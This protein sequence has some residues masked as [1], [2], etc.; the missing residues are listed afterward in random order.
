MAN[1]TGT[2]TVN[3]KQVLEVDAVPSAGAG[4]PA[5]IGSL[6]MFN[7]AGVGE[8]Y[9]K[10]GAADTAWTLVDTNASD[11]HLTGNILTGGAPDTPNEFIGSTND[12]DFIMRRNNIEQARLQ[13]SQFLIG[14]N[15]GIGGIL[16]VTPALAGDDIIKSVLSPALNPVISVNR[17]FRVTTVGAVTSTFDVSVPSGYNAKIQADVIVVQTG[18]GT[19]AAQDGAG[20]VRTVQANNIA[21]VASKLFEQTDYTYEIDSAMD[22]TSAAVGAAIRFSAL[23]AAGRNFSWGIE[24]KLHLITT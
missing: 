14:L 9:L 10:T 6:A 20:Y 13:A 19:G 7:N 4:T 21:G 2:I 1:K 18:G 24:S 8:L 23:G 3:L 15:A 22:L 17:I 5:P 12:F 16:Q 11:W